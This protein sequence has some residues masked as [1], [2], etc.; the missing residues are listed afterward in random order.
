MS[1]FHY[2]TLRKLRWN[3][4]TNRAKLPTTNVIPTLAFAIVCRHL[5]NS[6]VSCNMFQHRV[7][8]TRLQNPRKTAQNEFG[9]GL[10]FDMIQTFGL[11]CCSCVSCS[12]WAGRS[13][14]LLGGDSSGNTDWFFEN[15]TSTQ[16][17]RAQRVWC[18]S[19]AV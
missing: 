16:A 13:S 6:F 10:S 7:N 14:E 8:H 19:Q 4:K 18:R 9:F 11:L 12:P 2:R 15:S 5:P 3:N 1:C 17:S